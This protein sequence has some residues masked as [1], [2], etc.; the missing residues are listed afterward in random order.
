M[1]SLNP[2]PFLRVSQQANNMSSNRVRHLIQDFATDGDEFEVSGTGA[3][4][5]FGENH[6]VASTTTVAQASTRH[7]PIEPST[8]Q[9]TTIETRHQDRFGG[10]P[11]NAD[12]RH[13]NYRKHYSEVPPPKDHV[14]S[15]AG[16]VAFGLT[17]LKLTKSLNAKT[18]PTFPHSRATDSHLNTKNF[19]TDGDDAPPP[20]EASIDESTFLDNKC[21]H[22][23]L[24]RAV[25]FEDTR[26]EHPDLI[27][28]PCV[29]SA[30]PPA[31]GSAPLVPYQDPHILAP[32]ETAHSP[33]Y[34]NSTGQSDRA[35][36]ERVAAA[37]V[38]L[39]DAMATLGGGGMV[40]LSQCID[41][42][43]KH[44]LSQ[45]QRDHEDRKEMRK[46]MFDHFHQTADRE[47][48]QQHHEDAMTASREEKWWITKVGTGCDEC[49]HSFYTT[50]L[51]SLVIHFGLKLGFRC[52][53]Y[54]KA[55]Q[56]QNWL[57]M[58]NSALDKVSLA[59][60]H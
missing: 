52:W 31:P 55:L 45:E 56:D 28:E 9:T 23:T 30:P 53:A 10:S 49:C 38:T 44:I 16:A 33:M 59:L 60:V 17:A 11:T 12:T 34:R 21:Y 29:R 26:Y 5:V 18:T 27:E 43:S 47:Q 19:S 2:S 15:T 6:S 3:T 51:R 41:L 4:F 42:A 54:R 37:A 25:S 24:S 13:S 14:S 8:R 7:N 50:T 58:V 32:F 48:R 57:D 40:D 36:I 22:P 39:L 35:S 1:K 20:M 46:M